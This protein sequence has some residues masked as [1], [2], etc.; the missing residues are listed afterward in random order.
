MT[1]GRFEARK[2]AW[3]QTKDGIVLSLAVHPNDV[4]PDLALADIGTILEIEYREPD[5]DGPETPVA[6]L[7]KPA[8]DKPRKPWGTMKLSAQAGIRCADPQFQQ[9][10]QRTRPDAWALAMTLPDTMTDDKVAAVIV[11]EVCRVESR[12]HLDN[13]ESAAARWRTLDTEFLIATGQ[14]AEDYRR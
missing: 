14:M 3:R 13:V 6:E 5:V 1:A 7:V 4:P 10:L 11:R 8:P 9:W 2:I 12:Q